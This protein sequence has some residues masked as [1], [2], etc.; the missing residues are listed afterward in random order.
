MNK[1]TDDIKISPKTSVVE[2]ERDQSRWIEHKENSSETSPLKETKALLKAIQTRAM[3]EVH[4]AQDLTL[5]AYISAVRRS[6]EAVEN[7]KFMDSAKIDAVTQELIK[8]AQQNWKSVLTE[9][10]SLRG[11]LVEAAE[12]AWNILMQSKPS[13]EK[14]EVETNET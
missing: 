1:P 8:D 14:S 2:T 5:D 4:V 11:R 6:K 13:N 10:E 3:A 7:T 9:I 12:T